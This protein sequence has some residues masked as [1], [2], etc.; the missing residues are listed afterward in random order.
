M[1][2]GV[3]GWRARLPPTNHRR[4]P[5]SLH[6][7]SLLEITHRHGQMI[8]CHPHAFT[9]PAAASTEEAAGA[10]RW[11]VMLLC[12]VAVMGGPVRRGAAS[13]R[14]VATV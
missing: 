4:A 11:G 2:V 14:V 9:N 10:L 7:P 3:D 13:A 8:V 1:G 6:W 12:F 5:H